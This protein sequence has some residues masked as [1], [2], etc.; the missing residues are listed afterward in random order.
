MAGTPVATVH[1]DQARQISLETVD[2]YHTYPART[3]TQPALI[4]YTSR[5]I[6]QPLPAVKQ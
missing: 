1:M 2:Y 6:E 5:F 3:L 4:C